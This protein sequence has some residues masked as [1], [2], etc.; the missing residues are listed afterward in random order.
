MR[1]GRR[2]VADVREMLGESRFDDVGRVSSLVGVA[3]A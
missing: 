2:G 1:V 3:G